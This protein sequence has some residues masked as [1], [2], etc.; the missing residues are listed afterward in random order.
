MNRQSLEGLLK[1]IAA[2]GNQ[3]L[4]TILTPITK[5]V[6]LN[7]NDSRETIRKKIE[8]SGYSFFPVYVENKENI[9]G[10]IHVKEL[11]LQALSD[12]KIDLSENLRE[13]VYFSDTMTVHQIYDIFFQS[14]TKAAFVIDKNKN[15]IG[16]ITLKDVIRTFL[17]HIP[18]DEDLNEPYFIKRS[19]GSWLLDG[20]MPSVELKKLLELK[21]LPGEEKK[22]YETLGGFIMDYL[23]K[24]PALTESF[25]FENFN[26]EIVDM[27][28]NRIDKVLVKQ[29]I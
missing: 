6:F 26:F 18:G 13:P 22:S 27:D 5:I 9:L 25:Q 12:K 23:G 10:I 21:R 19:D 3:S 2:F 28:G 4:R 1:K 7:I 20:M 8:D 17:G 24:I 16:V 29:I 14:G 15:V 11:L